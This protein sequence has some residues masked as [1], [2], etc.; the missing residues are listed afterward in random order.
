MRYLPLSDQ[1]RRAML[2]VVGVPSIDGLFADVPAAAR[3]T[4]PIADLPMHKSELAVEAH[5]SALAR[6]NMSAAHHPFF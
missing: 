5:F 6:S 2:D 4:G 3:L 1:D